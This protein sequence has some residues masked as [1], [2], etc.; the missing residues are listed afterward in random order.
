MK[1]VFLL[2]FH[3]N[4]R[5]NK[6][7]RLLMEKHDVSVIYWQKNEYTGAYGTDIATENATCIE[8]KFK[9]RS[10]KDRYLALRKF[11]KEATKKLDQI[12]PD[13]IYVQ[14]LDLFLYVEKYKRH[15]QNKINL[16]YEVSDI[17]DILIQP[18]KKFVKKQIQSYLR[19]AEKKACK[20]LDLFCYTSPAFCTERYGEII[21]ENKRMYLPNIPNLS[22]FDQYVPHSREDLTV[23]F[24]GTVRYENQIRDM[25]EAAKTAG[26][27]SVVAGGVASGGSRGTKVDI[28]KLKK[29]YPDT[30]FIGAFD[31]PRDIADIYSKINVSY[32]VYD[33]NLKNV[34]IALPNKL[35]EAIRCGIP[36]IVAPNTYLAE[37]VEALGIGIALNQ[38]EEIASFLLRLKS[39]NE[40]F[41]KYRT[42]CAEHKDF[43][44]A[45]SINEKF[46]A[47][48]E[49]RGVGV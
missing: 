10:L 34:K 13:C 45:E 17:N 8:I 33:S 23:G 4:Q 32:A 11:R 29:E 26:I 3:P 49:K 48:F 22:Y 20:N 44:D 24:I 19:R 40:A 1:I 36:I 25:L 27:K 38:R 12:Q 30:E 15:H 21:S 42:A 31:Y 9:E 39:D 43:I 6:R 16:I 35:Y 14:N 5:I 47:W 41:L 46:C 7:I 18:Q 28:E 37:T 2:G